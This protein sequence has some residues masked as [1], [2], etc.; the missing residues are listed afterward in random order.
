M[1]IIPFETRGTFVSKHLS[2]LTIAILTFMPSYASAS[3]I[4]NY[5]I[6]KDVPRDVKVGYVIGVMDAWTRIS[7]KGEA[8]WEAVQRVGVNRCVREQE[9]SADELVI[10]VDDH[11]QK[12]HA[13]RPL[14]P[15]LVL[16]EAVMQVCLDAVNVERMKEGMTP[17]GRQSFPITSGE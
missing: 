1:C 8:R 12:H 14:W 5:Q 11:Y 15:A 16:R 4:T 13:D 10:W 7:T 3:F 6:W 2:I 9:I 17:W